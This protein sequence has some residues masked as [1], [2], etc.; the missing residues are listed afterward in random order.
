M[1][2]TSIIALEQMQNLR[3]V[4]DNQSCPGAREAYECMDT[5]IS[6]YIHVQPHFH[7]TK[8]NMAAIYRVAKDTT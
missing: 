4:F 6:L 2:T 1:T 8:N 3:T 7:T 5:A